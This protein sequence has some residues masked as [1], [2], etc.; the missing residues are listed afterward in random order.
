MRLFLIF[1]LLT[2]LFLFSQI[3]IGDDIDG[4][5]AGDGS[6]YISFSNDGSIVAIGGPGNDTA[7]EDAGHV[8][9]FQNMSGVWTQIGSDINCISGRDYFGTSVSIS[10]DGSVVAIGASGTNSTNS[11][12]VSVFENVSGVW[13]QVGN[14]LYGSTD[15]CFGSYVSLSNNGSMITVSGGENLC[16]ASWGDGYVRIYENISGTWTQIGNEIEI[17]STL[18][19]LITEISS[20]SSMVF[21]SAQ[22]PWYWFGQTWWTP[23]VTVFEKNLGVWTQVGTSVFSSGNKISIS[24]NG[25]KLA[26]IGDYNVNAKVYEN[27]SGVW[28]QIG[29][30]IEAEHPTE[31][32]G[33]VSLSSDGSIVAISGYDNLS[34]ETNY[35]FVRL[36]KNISGVWSEIGNNIMG[37]ALGDNTHKV[38]LSN[39][40]EVIAIGSATN[41][42]NGVDS[43]H[44]RVY[45]LSAILSTNDYAYSQFNMYPNPAKYQF[46]IKLNDNL[47][48]ENIISTMT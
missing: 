6:G 30:T 8:R 41:D 32:G 16:N 38:K 23:Y 28:T 20:D 29:N 5:S 34:S 27:I 24:N 35:G 4:V 39:E 10:G 12:Y 47:E 14:N 18:G 36:Y 13:T 48:L 33:E 44:V 19:V 45:D 1:L 7:D 43:G 40:G 31:V 26:T 2:P 37:E 21:I 11:G 46:T 9:V 22:S 3:Q 42:S 17:I 15:D 25:I